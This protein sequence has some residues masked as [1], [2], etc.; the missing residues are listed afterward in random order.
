M[1]RSSGI[2]ARQV[3]AAKVVLASGSGLPG[4]DKCGGMDG[5]QVDELAPQQGADTADAAD[6][7]PATLPPAV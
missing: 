3:G 6:A 4:N 1:H 7:A 2:I 5:M